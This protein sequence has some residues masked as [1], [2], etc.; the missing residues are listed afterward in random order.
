M[1]DRS[2]E[3]KVSS[4]RRIEVMAD[5]GRRRSWSPADKAAMVLESFEDGAVVA[6]I[7]RR[8]GVRAQQIHGWRRDAREG[9]LALPAEDQRT[10]RLAFAPV[11]LD[12]RG[13]ALAMSPRMPQGSAAPAIEIE[14]GGVRILVHSADAGLAS[15]LI[16]VLKERE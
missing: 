10:V 2:D 14:A 13:P 4:F 16:R 8:R 15:A 12:R 9:R 6:E 5:A 1:V 7:A 3:L 11:V